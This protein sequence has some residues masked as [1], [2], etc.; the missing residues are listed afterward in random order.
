MVAFTAVALILTMIFF[1][2][3]SITQTKS[4]DEEFNIIDRNIFREISFKKAPYTI[5]RKKKSQEEVY[6]YK[7]KS[8]L[9]SEAW[10]NTEFFL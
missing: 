5:H 4:S 3:K 9:I 1:K 8:T 7:E 6:T 2:E 10:N